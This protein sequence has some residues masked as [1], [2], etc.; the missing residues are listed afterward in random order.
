MHIWQAADVLFRE[1]QWYLCQVQ[2]AEGITD[3]VLDQMTTYGLDLV[4]R[5]L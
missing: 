1:K 3:F 4:L 2:D 5:F